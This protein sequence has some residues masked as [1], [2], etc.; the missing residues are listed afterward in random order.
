MLKKIL[1]KTSDN[2]CNDWLN[3]R[4]HRNEFMPFAPV[5][6]NENASKYLIN[7][8]KILIGILLIFRR[9]CTKICS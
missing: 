8:E 4:M 7:Y 9:V 2:T 5:M 1:Y 3:K 6:T